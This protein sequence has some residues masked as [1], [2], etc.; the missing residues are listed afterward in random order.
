MNID[1]ARAILEAE[2]VLQDKRLI[3][4]AEGPAWAAGSAWRAYVKEAGRVVTD[5]HGISLYRNT[6]DDLH[7]LR[8]GEDA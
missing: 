6:F 7:L 3:N 4:P 8:R 5:P 1:Q 2:R